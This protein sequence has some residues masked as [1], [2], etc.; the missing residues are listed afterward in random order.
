MTV[1][2]LDVETGNCVDEVNGY[3]FDCDE[4]YKLMSLANGSVCAAKECDNFLSNTVQWSRRGCERES[5]MML[6]QL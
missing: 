3:T 5:V 1:G 6:W 2:L 4:D